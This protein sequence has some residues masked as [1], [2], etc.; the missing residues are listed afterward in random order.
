VS[1]CVADCKSPVD[2]GPHLFGS[3]LLDGRIGRPISVGT[4]ETQQCTAAAG[5]K[6]QLLCHI[7]RVVGVL[8]PEQPI[9]GDIMSSS[10]RIPKA[11]VTGLYG[12]VVKRMS[13]KM[14]G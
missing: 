10:L 1:G 11:E 7:R 14:F 8:C 6:F 4:D 12:A 13:R 2:L 5:G 9:E 3:L